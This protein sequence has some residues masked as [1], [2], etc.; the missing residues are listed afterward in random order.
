MKIPDKTLFSITTN[1][2]RPCYVITPHRS[3]PPTKERG[4][5]HRWACEQQPVAPGLA[6][7]SH[8]GGQLSQTLGIVEKEDGAI[9]LVHP[10]RIQFTSTRELMDQIAWDEEEEAKA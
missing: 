5:F 9:C 7:G 1:E 3:T 8:P 6:R 4:L 2:Y 10:E